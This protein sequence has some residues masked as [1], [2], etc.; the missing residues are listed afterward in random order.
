MKKLVLILASVAGLTLV[1]SALANV[2]A[3]SHREQSRSRGAPTA[4]APQM[5]RRPLNTT[6][7]AEH[8]IQRAVPSRKERSIVAASHKLTT[9]PDRYLLLDPSAAA[10]GATISVQGGGFD[11]GAVV[12]LTLQVPGLEAQPV[13]SVRAGPGGSF[14]TTFV[15]PVKAIAPSARVLAQDAQGRGATA[16]LLLHDDQPLAGISPAVVRPGQHVSL[17]VAGFRPGETAHVY[18]ER[19]TRRPLF[20]GTVDGSGRGSWPLL[21][22]YGPGG[23]N[24]LIVVGDSG[25]IPVVA[26]YLLLD[27]Y[28]HAGVSSYAPQPG[29][30]VT[31][32]GGGFGPG[33]PVTLHL[34]RQD[35]PILAVARTNTHGGLPRLGPY[36]VPFGLSG[37][38]TFVLRSLDSHVVSAVGVTI[39]PFFANAR[40]ST[41]AAGPGTLI[42]F[43][44]GGFAPHEIVRVYVGRTTKRLGV[45]VAALRT[46]SRGQLVAG[47]GSYVLPDTIHSPTVSFA[48]VGD[49]S[50]AVARTTLRYLAPTGSSVLLGHTTSYQPPPRQ[51]AQPA[52][53]LGTREAVLIATPPRAVPG[54]RV[55]LWGEGFRPH[56]L[57]RLVL[58][59]RANPQGW[60]LGVAHASAGGTLSARVMIPTWV[61]QAD[62]VRTCCGPESVS[63]AALDIWPVLPHL[64]PSTYSGTAGTVYSLSGDGFA[65]GEQVSLH[66]DTI[67]APP[68]G[69][70][71]SSGGHVAFTGVRL[72]IAAPGSHTIVVTGAHGEVA[73]LPFTELPLTPFLLLSTYS[74]LPERP[75]S[76]SGQGFAPGE[77][78]HLFMGAAGGTFVG[79]A[80]ADNH[81]TLHVNSAFTIPTNA[82]GPLP[83]VAVG[84]VSGR[85]VHAP[86]NVR[87]FAPSL[88]LS[89][90]AGHPGTTVAFTGSGFARDDQ[91]RVYVGTATTPAARFRAQ[92]GAFTRAGTVRIAFGTRGGM[93]P[94]TVRGTRSDIKVTLRYLVI[95]FKP[96]AG[97]EARHQHGGTRLR[98]GAGGFA[99]HETVRLYSGRQAQGVPVRLLHADAAG[100]LPMVLVL[101]ARGIPRVHLAYSLVGVQSGAQA[102]ALYTPPQPHK[103]EKKLAHR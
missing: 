64:A 38:H 86:L 15:V 58:A 56:I 16:T 37:P 78:V 13:G 81:G 85:L 91:L 30:R 99:P 75:V 5:V 3:A 44:G 47:S 22:P 32:Y 49:V 26:R 17:W 33:E 54:D 84:S 23:Y 80:T 89:S 62:V 66:L 96:G 69:S 100:T 74:S 7:R 63:S 12:Q 67:T 95:P 11:R 25:E 34:D 27:L 53:A 36:Q 70:T 90:Y 24:Q 41:Y 1:G 65:P 83:V 42:T 19:L 8:R 97:F 88:W 98:L 2:P 28:P 46:T 21:I 45:E 39:E 93:L 103:S 60:T 29:T 101:R 102:T 35:G 18:S 71:T 57:I 76:V 6:G 92:Q 51:H 73:T 43:Y 94:L 4:H 61:T 52:V 77:T 55:V 79:A 14:R 50:R 20:T 48:L 59:S 82:H 10:P 31:F 40:P 68:L 9:A 87:P 72:P